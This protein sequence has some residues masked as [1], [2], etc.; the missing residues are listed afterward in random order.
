V[1]NKD[2][3]SIKTSPIKRRTEGS[4]A[5]DWKFI[6]KMLRITFHECINAGY[7]R[8]SSESGKQF[9]RVVM[10]GAQ[11]AAASSTAACI[12]RLSVVVRSWYMPELAVG[13]FRRWAYSREAYVPEVFQAEFVEGGDE[14]SW[15]L[16]ASPP[17]SSHRHHSHLQR[18]AREHSDMPKKSELAK[19]A[20]RCGKT[21]ASSLT[22]MRF[23][24]SALVT[25]GC[26][27]GVVKVYTRPVSETT[28]SST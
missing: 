7:W 9:V 19:R 5:D 21:L 25:R 22:W 2:R 27:F 1:Y 16:L 13:P 15:A 26:S 23:L 11:R 10:T 8:E 12:G 24:P 14:H 17:R 20:L 6:R 3:M 28:S 4:L 18:P